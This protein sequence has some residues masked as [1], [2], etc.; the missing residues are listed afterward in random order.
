[1]SL[2]TRLF[3]LIALALA[4]CAPGGS[5]PDA[6]D[7]GGSP[8]PS[9]GP[10]PEAD[11]T[12]LFIGNSLTAS[13]DLPGMVQDIAEAAGHTFEYRTVLRGNSS[14]EDHWNLGVERVIE[15]SQADFVVMQQGPSS[16][17]T[18]PAYLREWTEVL[19]PAIRAAAGEPALLMVWPEVT[20]LEAFDAVRD[21]YAGAAEAVNGI[22]IPAGEAWREIW[23]LDPDAELYGP[24]GFHPSRAG[25]FAAA[26]TVYAALFG[27]DPRTLPPVILDAA[28]A[29]LVYE[30]VHAAVV[31]A[32]D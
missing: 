28:A 30:G 6:G 24:D 7:P 5:E 17:G 8:V 32:S 14:L 27:E 23:A 20:R 21:S 10:L 12:V 22:F 3:A 26:V 4:A 19:A 11:V 1:M 18:N 29:S 9:L 15:A 2:P 16:V 31:A 13:N 25:S